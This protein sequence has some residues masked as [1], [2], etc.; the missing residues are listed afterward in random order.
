MPL[1]AFSSFDNEAKTRSIEVVSFSSSPPKQANK[2]VRKAITSTKM[3]IETWK[4]LEDLQ[5]AF[6]AVRVFLLQSLELFNGKEKRVESC[7][8]ERK[9]VFRSSKGKEREGGRN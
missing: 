9:S 5:K 8:E 7:I 3:L 4:G 1:T 2:F 6:D